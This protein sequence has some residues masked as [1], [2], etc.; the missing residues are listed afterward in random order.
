MRQLVALVSPAWQRFA[1][2]RLALAQR[3]HL[4]GE[5]AARGLDCVS[6]IVADDENLDIA[7]EYGAETV[8]M[9]NDD[10]LALGRKF[11]AGF[12][13]AAALGADWLVHMGSD[14]WIH[15]DAFDP[16]ADLHGRTRTRPIVSGRQIAFVNLLTGR[17]RLCYAAGRNGVVPWIIPRKLMVPC[18]FAPIREDRFRGMD[19]YLIRGLRVKPTW[20]HHDPHP[21]G[22][23]D[24]KSTVNLN[25]YE[26]VSGSL[27]R[28]RGEVE[29]WGLLA[30]HYP[31]NLVEMARRTHLELQEAG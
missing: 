27:G 21:M 17:M 22:R 9:A 15:P 24:W 16:L 28:R 10:G 8:E 29:P 5:L 1:V 31:A 30:E 4:A 13:H 23:V 14:D 26:T 12:R 11:N 19:G 7:R 18:D 3:A 20:L 25:S 2:T 6:V